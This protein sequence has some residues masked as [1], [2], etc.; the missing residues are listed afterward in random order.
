MPER[1]AASVGWYRPSGT[2]IV[3]AV[4]AVFL[5]ISRSESA[6]SLATPDLR[7]MSTEPGVGV[8]LMF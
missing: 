2:F 4:I 5:K 1:S 8:F 6:A 3:G 7:V